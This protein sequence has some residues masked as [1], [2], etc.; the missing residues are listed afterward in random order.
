M[1]QIDLKDQYFGTEIEMTGI[2]R[3]DA[4]VA[5][6]R[7]FGTEPYHIRSYDSWCVKDSDGKTWK[8]SRDSSIDCER[9][10][11]GTVIDADG[12]YSTEMV[13]PKLEYSEMGKLQEVVRCV[14]NAGAFVNSSCGMHVHVDASNH[15]PRSLKNALTIMYCKEDILFKAL[16]VQ[17]RREDEYCQKVR[18]T[19]IELK[20]TDADGKISFIADLPIDG[21]YYVKELYA[22][23]GFVTTGEEQEFVFEYQGDKE[24]EASYEFVF[25]DEPT[26]VELSK[27]DLTTGEELPGARLQLTDENGAVVEEWTSTK[28]PH[29]IKELVV[30]KSYTLTE[31]KPADGYATAESITFTVENTAE[32]QKQVMEDDVTK[33]KIS[34]TDITGD[35]EI[36]GAKLTITDENGNIVET[37]TSGKEPH[38]IEK[39]PIGKYTLKEEQAPNGY[40]VA[41]EI[42]F[43]VADTAEI[44]KVA[45]KDDTAKGRLI[46]E[47]TDKDAGAA[48]KDAE[49][50]LRDADGKVVETL[51]TDENGHATSGLLAIGTYKDGKFDK[52]ATYYLVETKAPEGYQLD[53]TKHEV[54]FTYVDDKTPVIEVIQKVTNEKLPEDTPF[55]SNPK[56]GDD[57]NLWIPA[58]CLILSAGGLIGMGVASRRKKKKGGR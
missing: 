49:F 29:I 36:E 8:F 50:E 54:T 53:E 56:T 57:T 27:T 24:A 32:I 5:I 15:T 35:N 40:V 48:L 14:K 2:S 23:D 28:E 16:N 3:Y 6:G 21:T 47:K 44:Q 58:L 13:S 38:Y 31:N 18:P 43:E 12:D 39:L 55:V 34:K 52:A 1:K 46:I 30:G 25:E 19:L 42:T 10:A 45:M 37:W 51:T 22:P 26:T 7:M 33:V 4:A 9:L 11:N 20:T 41:E 17:T